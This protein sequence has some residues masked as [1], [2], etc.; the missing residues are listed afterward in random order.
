[1]KSDA[2]GDQS[3]NVV[4]P[5]TKH[6]ASR[7]KKLVQSSQSATNG[8]GSIL[9]DIKGSKHACCTDSKSSNQSSNIKSRSEGSVLED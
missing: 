8:S 2:S 9:A 1:M 4:D 3:T 5:K 7:D 6:C